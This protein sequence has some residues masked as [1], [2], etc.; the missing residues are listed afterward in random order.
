MN[1]DH[2]RPLTQSE[3]R[4]AQEYLIDLKMGPAY[5]RMR[6]AEGE[7]V[8]DEASYTMGGRWYGRVAV[9]RRIRQLQ[10]E[11]KERTAITADAVLA[12]WWA[13]ANANPNGLMQ[14]HRE[15]CRHCYGN[16]HKYQWRD[17]A[18][19]GQAVENATLRADA[20][21][22]KLEAAG[23]PRTAL[24][25]IPD[26]DGGFGFDS[27]QV[28]HPDC[29]RCDGKGADVR[30]AVADTRELS[31]DAALLYAGAKQ[32]K[33]GIEI[34]TRDQDA[35]LINV[36]RHL[37]MLN[38]KLNLVF[39]SLTDEQLAGFTRQAATQAGLVVGVAGS[40]PQETG[41]GNAE[42]DPRGTAPVQASPI[43]PP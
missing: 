10:D 31:G 39:E 40:G 11:R 7:P 32:T 9:R 23:K 25:T 17:E 14:V 18:E 5:Q 6:A 26:C 37:G 21:N 29:P 43:A 16:G 38:D 12:R 36:A 33:E 8:T 15:C 30:V 41:V 27:N 28:P 20:E 42:V 4:F 34:R 24:P 2:E 22:E 19:W 1:M 13:I 35:A 3:E